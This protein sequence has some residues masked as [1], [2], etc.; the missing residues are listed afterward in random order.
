MKRDL[1]EFGDI[2]SE[3]HRLA[4]QQSRLRAKVG[5]ILFLYNT[6]G[7]SCMYIAVFIYGK[8]VGI[9]DYRSVQYIWRAL[10]ILSAS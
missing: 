9:K 7:S 6:T 10:L 8:S 3:V 5:P 1:Q 4:S 2:I